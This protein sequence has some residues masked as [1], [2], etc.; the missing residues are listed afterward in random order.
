MRK[1]LICASLLLTS[2]A[3]AID[4]SQKI[5]SLEG[6]PVCAVEIKPTEECP[7]DKHFTLALAARNALFSQFEDEK[8]LS[9]EDK[10]KR[11]ALATTIGN[12]GEVKLKAEDVALLKK[13]IGKAYGPLLVLQAWNMLEGKDTK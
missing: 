5:R 10:Y 1:F 11:A 13:L 2:P 12:G 3:W 9:G 7:A 8:N 4:F 6:V